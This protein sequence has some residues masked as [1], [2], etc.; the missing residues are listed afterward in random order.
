MHKDRRI[1]GNKMTSKVV[2]WISIV[3]AIATI[4]LF[5]FYIVDLRDK[6]NEL[7]RKNTELRDKVDKLERLKTT[8]RNLSAT[9]IIKR[10]V[11]IEEMKPF[12]PEEEIKK[13]EELVRSSPQPP[14]PRPVD[15]DVYFYPSGWMGDGEYGRRYITFTRT[16]EHIKITYTPGPKGWAGIYWQY[17]D[18]NWGAQPGRNLR[19]VQRLTFWA[20]GERGTEI[21][22]FKTGGI[23][24]QTY[25]DSFEKSLGRI[26]LSQEWK[27]Y[28]I[29]L[30]D[31]DLSSVIGAFAWIASKDANPDGLTFYLKGIYFYF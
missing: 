29:D 2:R 6:V 24:G 16:A 5:I 15:I 1:G 18:K 11:S 14:V 26:K 25:K 10:K 20:K 13:I 8:Y 28:E 7:E 30:T 3:A 27:Q 12:L 19:G 21:V 31:Q 22:E 4:L 23:R 9:L 17:P